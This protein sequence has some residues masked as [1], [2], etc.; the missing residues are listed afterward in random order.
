M[1]LFINETWCFAKKTQWSFLVCTFS[2]LANF[3]FAKPNRADFHKFVLN[4]LTISSFISDNNFTY[5]Q[6]TIVNDDYGVQYTV[7]NNSNNSRFICNRCSKSYAHKN[8]LVRHRKYECS[9]PRQFGCPHC[10]YKARRKESLHCH[11]LTCKGLVKKMEN[12][13]PSIF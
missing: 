6:A 2:L 11:L 5:Q 9:Q 13:G 12:A 3:L 1:D 7:T 8:S 4:F 10:T